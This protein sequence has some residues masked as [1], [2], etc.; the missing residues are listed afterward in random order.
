LIDILAKK[1]PEPKGTQSTIERFA[2]AL[3]WS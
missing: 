3:G 1:G 2:R